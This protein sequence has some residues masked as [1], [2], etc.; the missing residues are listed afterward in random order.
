M[1]ALDLYE[2]ELCECGFHKSLAHDPDQWF[3]LDSVTC[4]LCRDIS[5]RMRETAEGDR[6]ED[7]AL[8]DH[9]GKK[10]KADGR[11]WSVKWLPKPWSSPK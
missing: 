3:D 1:L 4:P 7:E 5:I 9:P 11:I 10:R 6:K 2:S 8:R